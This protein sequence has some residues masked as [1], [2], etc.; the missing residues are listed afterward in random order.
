MSLNDDFF[1]VDAALE[2]KPEAEA[3]ARIWQALCRAEH[4]QECAVRSLDRI[5]KGALELKSIERGDWK[6]WLK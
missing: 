5:E 3:F 1:D 6:D 2:G 4:F